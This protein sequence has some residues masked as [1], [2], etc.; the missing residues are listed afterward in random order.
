[1][2]DMNQTKRMARTA[3]AKLQ[4][5]AQDGEIPSCYR[6]EEETFLCMMTDFYPDLPWERDQL[7]IALRFL[8]EDSECQDIAREFKEAFGYDLAQEWKTAMEGGTEE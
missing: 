7:D 4:K 8:N 6:K 2:T 1:M 5:Y 3:A